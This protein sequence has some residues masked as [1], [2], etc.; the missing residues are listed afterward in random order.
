MNLTELLVLG[1][2]APHS[3]YFAIMIMIMM[4]MLE[5]LTRKLE[6]AVVCMDVILSESC[7]GSAVCTLMSWALV[8]ICLVSV[9]V[10]ASERATDSEP[11]SESF[12]GCLPRYL[13]YLYLYL[14]P[15]GGL[16]VQ[17]STSISRLEI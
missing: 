14:Y 17:R 10:R 4:H 12:R 5:L 2:H 8:W 1:E 16:N 13:M 9:L 15:S 3:V 6:L 7:D 11:E